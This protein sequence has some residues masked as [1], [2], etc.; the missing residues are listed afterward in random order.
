MGRHG[1][2]SAD[3]STPDTSLGARRRRP[4]GPP[5]ARPSLVRVPRG[6]RRAQARGSV[7]CWPST[8]RL[9]A[10]LRC[11]PL[12]AEGLYDRLCDAPQHQ[13]LCGPVPSW[14]GK[15]QKQRST[16]KPRTAATQWLNEDFFFD[17][18][19]PASVRKLAQDQGG[20]QGAAAQAGH[21]CSGKGAAL[22]SLLPFL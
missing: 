17:G 16:I 6:A 3:D 19:G 1:S 22:T 21:A 10:R 12:A 11:A 2:P 8:R 18:L 9:Q 15:L 13:L 20:E 7:R 14:P 5:R 4:A